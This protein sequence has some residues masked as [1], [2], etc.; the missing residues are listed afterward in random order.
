MCNSAVT[1][2]FWNAAMCIGSLTD[3]KYA[4]KTYVKKM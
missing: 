3:R 1:I 4:K 2:F